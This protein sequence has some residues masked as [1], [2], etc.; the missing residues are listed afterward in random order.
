[1]PPADPR[2]LAAQPTPADTDDTSDPRQNDSRK[3]NDPTEVGSFVCSFLR[4]D[5]LSFLRIATPSSAR[6]ASIMA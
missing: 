4:V 6:P 3:E 1:M 5:Y 2:D